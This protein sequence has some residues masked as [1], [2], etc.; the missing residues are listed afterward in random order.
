VLFFLGVDAV[1]ADRD[2]DHQHDVHAR[3]DVHAVGV[4]DP[5]PRPGHL[6]EHLPA[7][8]DLEVLV[9]DVADRLEP[10]ASGQVD[11][12]PVVQRREHR[13]VHRGHDRAVLL[14]LHRV[15]EGQQP[16]L[17]REQ[18]GSR[19]VLEVERVAQGQDLGVDEEDLVALL[20]GDPEVILD[21]EKP[22]SHEIAHARQAIGPAGA[23]TLGP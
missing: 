20:V 4:A 1:Q 18:L 11:D 17:D 16:V 15:G 8:A 22:L 9:E 21:G 7:V 3:R 5:E 19:G 14:D 12:R 2:G 10:R 6:G 13:L 23:R